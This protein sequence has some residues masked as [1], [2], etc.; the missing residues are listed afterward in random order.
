MTGLGLR[1]QQEL[2]GQPAFSGPLVR[3]TLTLSHSA[4]E[5][6]GKQAALPLTPLASFTDSCSHEESCPQGPTCPAVASVMSWIPPRLGS[7]V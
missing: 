2:W 5:A 6:R 1:P 4:P 7:A 3:D